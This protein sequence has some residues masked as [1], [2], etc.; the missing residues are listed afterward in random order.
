MKK[1]V[2]LKDVH[3]KFTNTEHLDV[4]AETINVLNELYHSDLYLSPRADLCSMIMSRLPTD[5]EFIR[6][7]VNAY[8]GEAFNSMNEHLKY[9]FRLR[10]DCYV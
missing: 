5:N 3:H 9:H 2:L 1:K 10:K 4:I 7:L 6:D 8:L